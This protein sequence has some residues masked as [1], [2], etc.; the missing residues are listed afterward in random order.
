MRVVFVVAALMVAAVAGQ[1]VQILQNTDFDGC[2]GNGNPLPWVEP[3]PSVTLAS[4]ANLFINIPDGDVCF[5]GWT[6]FVDETPI[7]QT[8]DISEE[9]AA[10]TYEFEA[11]VAC[12]GISGSCTFFIEVDGVRHPVIYP[13][14]DPVQSSLPAETPAPF[15]TVKA[16]GIDVSTDSVVAIYAHVEGQIT[17]AA[18]T[19]ATLTTI[20]RTIP[21]V[22]I[23]ASSIFI[24]EGSEPTTFT[25][26]R[27]GSTV[28][29]LTVFLAF[30]GSAVRDFDY[31]VSDAV[32][33]NSVAI[34]VGASSISF[35]VT[36]LQDLEDEDEETV[37]VSIVNDE[38]YVSNV[39]TAEV[40]IEDI[41]PSTVTITADGPT[42]ITEGSGSSFLVDLS[43]TSPTDSALVVY[44]TLRGTASVNGDF[45]I[46]NG[47]T[48]LGNDRY[49][50]A[51]SAGASDATFSVAVLDDISEEESETIIFVLESGPT[52]VKGTPD[53]LTLTILDDENQED[54]VP[55]ISHM[56]VSVSQPS[57]MQEGSGTL[58]YTFTR[59][60]PFDEAI[61][62]NFKISGTAILN[63]DYYVSGGS[64]DQNG[65]GTALFFE[66]SETHTIVIHA[67]ID[68]IIEPIETIQVDILPPDA[69]EI[70]IIDPPSS[71]TGFIIDVPP[72]FPIL[73]VHAVGSTDVAEGDSI[74]FTID[75]TGVTDV[76]LTVHISFS[77]SATRADFT[78]ENVE[79]NEED[80]YGFFYSFPAGSTSEVIT[81]DI[82][83]DILVEREETIIVTLL[84]NDY[85]IDND[86]GSLTLT[87]LESDIP[88]IT[89]T[90]FYDPPGTPLFQFALGGNVQDTTSFFTFTFTLSSSTLTYNADFFLVPK[91]GVV[92]ITPQAGGKRATNIVLLITVDLSAGP[93]QGYTY[94]VGSSLGI[95]YSTSSNS[96]LLVVTAEGGS[97]I[98][99][100]VFKEEP[101]AP[102]PAN[103]VIVPTT[104]TPVPPAPLP[105]PS[106]A[107]SQSKVSPPRGSA[108]S[109]FGSSLLVVL[110]S[111]LAA[112]VLM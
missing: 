91:N 87:I 98:N 12:L 46:S 59:T 74:S 44:F 18:I 31:S 110:F 69:P 56:S 101:L 93:S 43:R 13:F 17:A 100:N 26:S 108:D 80:L 61:T 78:L 48:A 16:V 60:A 81:L 22:D 28:E 8:L 97:P 10:K 58:T 54:P 109:V 79:P 37:F 72:T 36:A 63:T 90:V 96:Q 39:P 30:S 23:A 38:S 9:N 95:P 3:Q 104:P 99:V 21:T 83:N 14:P 77:G 5:T 111:V 27:S 45:T 62:V 88:P 76:P 40:F 105:S 24:T 92:S 41:A 34:P 84:V 4:F 52:Y 94:L 89:L 65:V 49:S 67:Y 103:D 86:E 106:R 82:T 51:F 42:S 32:E 19:S 71:I 25:V 1:G 35:T 64:V 107:P 15:T 102:V 50:I 85:V 33:D 47:L 6:E 68:T 73:S 11:V 112:V 57:S 66:L 20:S 70:Y 53:T 75:R 55:A 29:A 2:L 7:T